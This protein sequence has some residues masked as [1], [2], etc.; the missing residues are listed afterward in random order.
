MQS[1]EYI[2]N[3]RDTVGGKQFWAGMS[4]FY[5]SYKFQIGNTRAFWDTLD[6][7]TGYDSQKHADR[8]PSLYR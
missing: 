7:A 1:S 6:T 3:Y 5:R 8:F 4:N 2:D